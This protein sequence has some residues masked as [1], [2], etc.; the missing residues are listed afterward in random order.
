M[1]LRI[2]LFP[3]WLPFFCKAFRA[4]VDCSKRCLSHYPDFISYSVFG[5]SPLL[6]ITF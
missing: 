2:K 3:P 4:V 6:A 1:E 5:M